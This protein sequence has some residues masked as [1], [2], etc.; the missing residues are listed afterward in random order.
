LRMI[1]EGGSRVPGRAVIDDLDL[2]RPEIELDAQLRPVEHRLHRLERP[3]PR[4]VERLAAQRVAGTDL[5]QRQA[6]LQ[7]LAVLEDAI[8][9]DRGGE[10]VGLTLLVL[11]VA[12]VPERAIEA[13]QEL[14]RLL[15][16]VVVHGIDADDPA[17][18]ARL[19]RLLAEERDIVRR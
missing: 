3:C 17:D 6:R 9:E 11:A 16:Q 8:L 14:W 15:E 4:I 1:L 18:P 19:R 2:P 5:E 10:G 13:L 7:P 12:V